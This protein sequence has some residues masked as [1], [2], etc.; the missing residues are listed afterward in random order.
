[1]SSFEI[2][3]ISENSILLTG[4]LILFG[5]T[6][7]FSYYNEFNINYYSLASTSEIIFSFLSIIIPIIIFISLFLALKHDSFKNWNILKYVSKINPT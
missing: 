3:K 6:Y 4:L 2:K 5:S 7:F 1:M